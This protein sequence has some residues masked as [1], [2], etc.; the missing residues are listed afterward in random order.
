MS[1]V[2]TPPIVR[3]AA[4]NLIARHGREAAMLGIFGLAGASLEK[5]T[6]AGSYVTR[7]L[8]CLRMDIGACR[9]KPLQAA[10]FSP[11]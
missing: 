2:S 1:A 11:N 6:G 3:Q 5:V 4:R 8:R 10:S 9:D 7:T